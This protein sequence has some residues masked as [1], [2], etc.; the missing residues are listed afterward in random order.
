M[1]LLVKNNT[2]S[3]VLGHKPEEIFEVEDTD[4]YVV[5]LIIREWLVVAEEPLVVVEEPLIIEDSN[6]EED[7]VLDN[8]LEEL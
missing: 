7:E 6:E 1:K 3:I 2:N 4:F 5:D 8:E